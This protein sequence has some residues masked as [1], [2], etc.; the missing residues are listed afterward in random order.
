MLHDEFFHVMRRVVQEH[1]ARWQDAGV[2]VTKPQYAVLRA[3]EEAPGLE[4]T[5]LAAG[6]ASTK[7]TLTE[8]LGRLEAA[9]IV[10]RRVD[11]VDRRRRYVDLTPEGVML[12]DEARVLATR[13]N[14]SF[15]EN[16]DASERTTL[17]TLLLRLE[18]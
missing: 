15:L 3:I 1:T 16:L 17:R 9:G 11:D 4:Q 10:S 7:A 2:P 14:E 13:V 8:I 6:S 18:D 5:A 12:L